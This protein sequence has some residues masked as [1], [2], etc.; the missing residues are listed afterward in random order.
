M[1]L[2]HK[3]IAEQ[4]ING[5]RCRKPGSTTKIEGKFSHGSTRKK[6]GKYKPEIR[7]LIF[8]VIL[9]C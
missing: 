8:S 4:I 6:H 2:L 7:R 5:P 3:D 1:E 9:P